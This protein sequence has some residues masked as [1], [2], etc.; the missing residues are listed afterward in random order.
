L[1]SSKSWPHERRCTRHLLRSNSAV[2]T[3]PLGVPADQAWKVL[4]SIGA[5]KKDRQRDA[6]FRGIGRLAGMAYCSE[7]LFRA[8]FPGETTISNIRF[9]CDK[10]LKAM[11]PDEGGETELASLLAK[12]IVNEPELDAAKAEEH[13]FEVRLIGLS[14]T[15]DSLTDADGVKDYLSETAPVDFAPDWPRAAEI[16]ADYKSYFGEE[17][18]TIDLFVVA[19]GETTQVFKPYG[20]AYQHAK[21]TM[22]LKSIEFFPGDDNQ[23]WGWVGRM[24]ESAAVTDWR[25]RGL[26]VRVRNIQVDGTEIFE[27][28]FTQVKP[29]Y[30]RFS[31]YH[32]GEIHIDA[33]SVIPN[34]R[35]DGF[36]ETKSWI[37]IKSSLMAAIC[38]PLASDAYD[39]S[40]KGQTQ[41]SK[42]VDDIDN[43]V[44]RG[45]TLA[46]SSRASYDQVVDLMNTAKR[47]RRR[48]ALAMKVVGDIDETA[49]ADGNPEVQQGMLLQ[50]AARSVETVE[51]QAKMLVGRFLDEEDRL[52][53]LRQRLRDEILKEVLDVVNAFA[54]PATYQK[55]RRKLV[56]G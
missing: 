29:S 31:S 35:R 15:P 41:I 49:V 8:S 18:E 22:D 1:S 23:Y 46:N 33:E 42:V 12:A 36:E 6:G 7:L 24:S 39:A 55:I 21:G 54:D 3:E 2:A 13:F 43:L 16:I 44:I 34:A 20:E 56:E 51:T 14:Q 5:S 4:T 17:P 19:E 52:G 27:N 11:N 28:L 50:D 10:L 30:G 37:D 25:T 47:L 48:A 32:V 9:D 26:R 53:A 45:Q 40:Q 38:Q